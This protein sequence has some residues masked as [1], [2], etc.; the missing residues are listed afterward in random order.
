MNSKDEEIGKLKDLPERHGTV[1]NPV[2][3]TNAKM[4]VSTSKGLGVQ[5]VRES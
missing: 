3:Q 1:V 2:A 4:E 5:R